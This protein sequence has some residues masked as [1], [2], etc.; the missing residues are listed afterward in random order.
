MNNN[1]ILEALDEAE[2]T[3]NAQAV[4]ELLP[5]WNKTESEFPIDDLIRY[6]K[7][8]QWEY[9]DFTF[10]MENALLAVLPKFVH[11]IFFDLK[12]FRDNSRN[13][14]TST[15]EAFARINAWPRTTQDEKAWCQYKYS[16]NK[17]YENS[18]IHKGE[19]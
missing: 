12:E 15:C 5:K 14:L 10:D 9:E 16:F 19:Q 4:L 3:D 1:D 8:H 11:D 2:G 18:N 7:M 13:E 6:V 17:Y